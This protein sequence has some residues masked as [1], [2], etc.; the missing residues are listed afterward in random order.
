[1]P[2]Q[3]YF[4]QNQIGSKILDQF[5]YGKCRKKLATVISHFAKTAAEY[6]GEQLPYVHRPVSRSP[7]PEADVSISPSKTADVAAA[8]AASATADETVA[9]TDETIRSLIE[10]VADDSVDIA[11][12]GKQPATTSG[13]EPVTEEPVIAD[14]PDLAAA[15]DELVSG[16]VQQ[17]VQEI[18]EDRKE[19]QLSAVVGELDLTVS[20]IQDET[21]VRYN[22]H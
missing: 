4:T 16:V 22:N 2:D 10:N 18:A 13:D 6:W 1:M 17:V 7:T 15:V 9:T 12:A 20:R 21:I 8:A 19:Q 5:N 3:R 11:L 14:S